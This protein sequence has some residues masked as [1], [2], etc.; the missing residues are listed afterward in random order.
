MSYNPNIS[1]DYYQSE[2]NMEY[3]QTKPTNQS[4][5]KYS[6]NIPTSNDS[7]YNAPYAQNNQNTQ[8][9]SN[10][11]YAPNNTQYAPNNTQYAPNNQYGPNNQFSYNPN[12]PTSNIRYG[13][14]N[15]KKNNYELFSDNPIEEKTSSKFNWLNFGKNIVIYTVLFLIMSH[16][17]MNYFVCKFIPFLNNNEVLCMTVKGVI[18]SIIIIVIQKLIK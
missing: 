6:N 12:I 4:K 3:I 14:G 7:N 5:K 17:K 16:M 11:Q 2:D 1:S 13:K 9:A 8:Y 10:T 15:M 18:M